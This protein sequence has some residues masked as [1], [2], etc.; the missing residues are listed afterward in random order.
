MLHQMRSRQPTIIDTTIDH[1]KQ[2]LRDAEPGHD[3]WHTFRVWNHAKLLQ[4]REGGDREIIELAALLHD[5]G[6]YKFHGGDVEVGPRTAMQ[7]L[8]SRG[9]PEERAGAVAKI[10]AAINFE[11]PA[12]EKVAQSIE[13]AVVQDADRLDALGAIGIARAFSF[14]GRFGREM[15]DPEILPNF[16]MRTE[17]YRNSKSPTLNHF[18]EKLLLLQ[19]RMLTETG[20]VLASKSHSFMVRFLTQFFEEF[21]ADEGPPE[22]WAKLIR[23]LPHS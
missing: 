5:L 20:R 3:W 14:G 9:Y 2:Q 17:E 19:D 10:I 12:G 4:E 21:F 23:D 16:S 18:F 6:D 1:V 7:W 13:H 11:G 8:V 15:L 22:T